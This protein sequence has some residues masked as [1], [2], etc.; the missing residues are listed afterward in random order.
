MKRKESGEREARERERGEKPVIEAERRTGEVGGQNCGLSQAAEDKVAIENN[1]GGE[2]KRLN[3]QTRPLPER[4]SLFDLSAL[5][6]VFISYCRV[7]VN[8]PLVDSE[9]LRVLGR[10]S[11]MDI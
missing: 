10:K 8:A 9:R 4:N 1:S 5:S 3:S 6:L 2:W 7:R 11:I